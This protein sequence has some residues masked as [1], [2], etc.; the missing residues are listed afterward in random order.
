MDLYETKYIKG[1]WSNPVPLD[2]INTAKDDQYVS[3]T[4]VGRYL[5]RDAIEVSASELV[6][7][8]IPTELQRPSVRG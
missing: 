3:A 8:P 6:E 4:S 1:Q 7:I 5:L 2:F